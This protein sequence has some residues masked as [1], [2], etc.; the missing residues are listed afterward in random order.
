MFLIIS[1]FTVCSGEYQPHAKTHM[2]ARK[3]PEPV[4]AFLKKAG[5]CFCSGKLLFLDRALVDM[6]RLGITKEEARQILLSISACDLHVG[7]VQDRDMPGEI[8]IFRMTSV[9]HGNLYI[10]IKLA[11]GNERTLC[12]SL[13]EWGLGPR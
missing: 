6:K 13:H 8:W 3:P 2:P 9:A 4:N 7:P 12:I 10:K 1:I 5:R 11:A